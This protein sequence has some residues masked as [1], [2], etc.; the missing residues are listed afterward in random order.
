MLVVSCFYALKSKFSVETY[1]KWI[2]YFIRINTENKE[3]KIII[4]TDAK[5]KKYL[6]IHSSISI[7]ECEIN[8]FYMFKYKEQFIHNFNN[9]K[10]FIELDWQLVML[11][12]EKIYFVK[13]ASLIYPDSKWVCWCDIGYFRCRPHKDLLLEELI[14]PYVWGEIPDW[15]SNEYIY[16]GLTTNSHIQQIK[17]IC[18]LGKEQVP[19]HQNSIAGGFFVCSLDKLYLWGDLFENKCIKYFNNNYIIKDD[20]IIIADCIFSPDTSIHF[21]LLRDTH[22]KYDTWFPFQRILRGI[23]KVE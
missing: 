1:S 5:S 15:F 11:W 6:P 22:I 17:S 14:H 16:Y 3:N 7:I 19:I 21:R 20:Q 8:E 2:T 23:K 13:K 10:S 12:C 18:S 4:F 9:N